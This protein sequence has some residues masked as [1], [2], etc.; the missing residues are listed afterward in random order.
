MLFSLADWKWTRASSSQM[1][2]D[3]YPTSGRRTVVVLARSEP[4][5]LRV[6]GE[7]DPAEITDTNPDHIFE[8]HPLTNVGSCDN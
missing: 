1:R 5:L 7:V 3:H 8:I 2:R 6:Q 4:L